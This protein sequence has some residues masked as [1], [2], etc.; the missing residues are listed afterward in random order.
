MTN[1]ENWIINMKIPKPVIFEVG[2]DKV[3]YRGTNTRYLRYFIQGQDV[4]SMVANAIG[5]KLSNA[6]DT[7]GCLIRHGCGMDIALSVIWDLN[8]KAETKGIFSENYKYLG[9]KVNGKYEYQQ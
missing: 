4:T 1:L 7:Y 3:N 5:G 2:L 6:K 8:S 9:K